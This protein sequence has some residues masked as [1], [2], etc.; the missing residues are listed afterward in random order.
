MCSRDLV[1]YGSG[2]ESTQRDGGESALDS[3]SHRTIT[4]GHTSHSG[5]VPYGS[6]GDS[7]LRSGR[8]STPDSKLR[9]TTTHG[10]TSSRTFVRLDS[11]SNTKYTDLQGDHERICRHH[12][13]VNEFGFKDDE[14]D[15]TE[16]ISLPTPSHHCCCSRHHTNWWKNSIIFVLA[17][18]VLFLFFVTFCVTFLLNFT[19]LLFEFV[20][21]LL[22]EQKG[23][24]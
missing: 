1:P 11:R 19:F 3:R 22:C 16:D 5:P 10:Y 2:R 13:S 21:F 8:D 20:I 24:T 15:K 7:T 4:R 23:G 18:C 17:I 12:T 6:G 9:R 14:G